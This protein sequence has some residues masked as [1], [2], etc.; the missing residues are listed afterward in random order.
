ME[1]QYYLDLASSDLRMPIGADLILHEHADAADI[2]L[3]GDRLGAIYAETARRFCTPLAVPRMDLEMEKELLLSLLG[4]PE[5]DIAK[6]HFTSPPDEAMVRRLD[7]Q[8]EGTL[9]PR[10][11]AQ[12]GAIRYIARHTDLLPMGMAIGPFSLMT[13]LVADP[14]TPVCLAGSGITA[15]DDEEVATVEQSLELGI[16]LILHY[17]NAQIDAGAKAI[18]IAEPAANKVYFSPNQL[19]DGSDIYDR[20]VMRYNYQIRALLD[21]RGVDL[22]FHCCGELTETMLVHF[23]RLDPAILSLGSSR[24]LWED[25]ALVPKT[26]VLYGNLPSKQFYSDALITVDDVK[27]RSAEL[28]RRMHAAGHPFILGSECDVLSVHGCEE[29]IRQKAFALL[30]PGRE[31]GCTQHTAQSAAV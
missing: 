25:A 1:R 4:I 30:K 8:L 19:D 9:T 5:A 3:D 2:L 17:I 20:Y 12:L 11:E 7:D 10:M 21:K 6:Y 26:T 23:T 31:C 16:R 29:T 27:A 22:V 15:E 24:V 13:K 14:I 18:F 28:V